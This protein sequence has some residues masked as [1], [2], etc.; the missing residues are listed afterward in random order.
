MRSRTRSRDVYV[1]GGSARSSR[2]WTNSISDTQRLLVPTSALCRGRPVRLPVTWP[3]NG[4]KR[5][6]AHQPAIR[7]TA[8][9]Y[10][11]ASGQF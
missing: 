11:T 2:V 10:R 1:R 6:R 9:A 3:G 7:A 5:R 8:A 4:L